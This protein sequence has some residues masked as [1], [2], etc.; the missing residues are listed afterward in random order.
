[1]ASG[2][3]LPLVTP[4]AFSPEQLAWIA[5]GTTRFTLIAPLVVHPPWAQRLLYT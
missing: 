1:M 5:Y 3:G 4:P 2:S